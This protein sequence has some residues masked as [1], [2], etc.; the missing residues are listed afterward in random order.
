MNQTNLIPPLRTGPRAVESAM[1]STDLL[2]I[3]LIWSVSFFTLGALFGLSV[4]P[5]LVH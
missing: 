3:G 2:W 5:A 1:T 4:A